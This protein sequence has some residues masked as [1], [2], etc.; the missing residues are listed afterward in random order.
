MLP[1]NSKFSSTKYSVKYIYA[2]RWAEAGL[3]WL[4][5]NILHD[6]DQANIYSLADWVTGEE[7]GS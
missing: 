4:K 1:R 6:T 2:E 3:K 7:F 5:I